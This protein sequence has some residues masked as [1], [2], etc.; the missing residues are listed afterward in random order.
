MPHLVRHG[1]EELFVLLD[2]IG[3]HEDDD[4]VGASLRRMAATLANTTRT[5]TN[6]IEYIL[7]VVTFCQHVVEL[8][9]QKDRHTIE[10]HPLRE[11]IGPLK[12]NLATEGLVG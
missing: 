11:R 2:L 1:L 6:R 7:E 10:I 9:D 5:K 3:I 4:T 12:G 8:V